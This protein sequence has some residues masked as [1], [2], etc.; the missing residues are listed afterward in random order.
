MDIVD[1]NTV[2]VL[3]ERWIES[4]QSIGVFDGDKIAVKLKSGREYAF[5]PV[6]DAQLLLMEEIISDLVSTQLGGITNGK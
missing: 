2:N 4:I 3:S 5:S 1:G 6:S